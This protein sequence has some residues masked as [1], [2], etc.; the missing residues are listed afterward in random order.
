MTWNKNGLRHGTMRNTE[1]HVHDLKQ[2]MG[3][4]M[5]SRTMVVIFTWGLYQNLRTNVHPNH[6]R[7]IQMGGEV[8]H[9]IESL[10]MT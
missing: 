3:Y 10:I 6:E 8:N 2:K 9:Y 4:A 7:D 5:E 1:T